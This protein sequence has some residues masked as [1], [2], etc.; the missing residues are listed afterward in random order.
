MVRDILMPDSEL[1][2]PAHII[3]EVLGTTNGHGNSYVLDI[4]QYKMIQGKNALS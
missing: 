1:W 4:A 3:G 2:F